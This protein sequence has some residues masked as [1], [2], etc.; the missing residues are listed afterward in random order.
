VWHERLSQPRRRVDL[1]FCGGGAHLAKQRSK[2]QQKTVLREM[3][4]VILAPMVVGRR[5][6]SGIRKKHGLMSRR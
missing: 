1:P 3:L 5:E 2:A 6:G 4:Y